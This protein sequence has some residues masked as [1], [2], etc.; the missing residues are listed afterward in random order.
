MAKGVLT[1]CES[2]AEM[3][4]PVWRSVTVSGGTDSCT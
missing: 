1:W 3:A 4:G 2:D